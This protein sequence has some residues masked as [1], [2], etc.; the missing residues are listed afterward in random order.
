M[1]GEC[2][3]RATLSALRGHR[4]FKKDPGLPGYPRTEATDSL[5]PAYPNKVTTASAVRSAA[6]RCMRSSLRAALRPALSA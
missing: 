4:S 2:S 5:G 3:L 6:P 1:V